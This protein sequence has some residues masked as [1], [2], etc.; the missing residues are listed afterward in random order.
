MELRSDYGGTPLREAVVS[1]AADAV[2]MLVAYGADLHTE[3]VEGNSLIH[4]AF[5]KMAKSERGD[6]KFTSVDHG[7]PLIKEVCKALKL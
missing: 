6:G 5:L 3:D 2:E 7:A 1:G 4:C